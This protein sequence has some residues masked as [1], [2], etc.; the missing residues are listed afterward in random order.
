[1]PGP[2]SRAMIAMPWRSPLLTRLKNISPLP[3]YVTILRASS[4]MV[5]ATSVAS[6]AEKP[7]CSAITLPLRRAV[8]RSLSDC[9]CMQTTISRSVTTQATPR[10]LLLVEVSK[11]FFQV[12]GG[13]DIFERNPELLHRERDFGLNPDDHGFG[14]AQANH[15]RKIAQGPRSEGIENIKRR[16]IDDHPTRTEATD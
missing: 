15:V 13:G 9:T 14:A 8:T 3:A 2:L 1:M 16:D 10:A 7:N 12:Q 6:L 5:V 4:E 11:A